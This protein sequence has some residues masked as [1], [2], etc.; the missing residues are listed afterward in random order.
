MVTQAEWNQ[1]VNNRLR[2]AQA[3]GRN[4]TAAAIERQLQGR[5]ITRQTLQP[6]GS[7]SGS[8]A[9]SAASST[10]P[11]A[12]PAPAVRTDEPVPSAASRYKNMQF[13]LEGLRRGRLNV[14]NLQRRNTKEF[15]ILQSTG[16]SER[17][18]RSRLGLGGGDPT[19]PAETVGRAEFWPGHR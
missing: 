12:R 19:P 17:E 5:G 15:M 7:K 1:Y 13:L 10:Q 18:V 8:K 4:V 3:E 6:A 11:A 16:E 2:L 9:G 14:D